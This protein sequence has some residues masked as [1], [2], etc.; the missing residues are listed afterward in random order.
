MPLEMHA[1]HFK[2]NYCTHAEALKHVDGIVCAV[3]MFQVK[4]CFND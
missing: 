1:I 2:S 3:Y 4:S